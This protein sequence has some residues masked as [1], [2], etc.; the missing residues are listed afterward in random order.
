MHEY[1]GWRGPWIENE[2][3]SRYACRDYAIFYP[4][5]PIFVQATDACVLRQ[6]MPGVE[7]ALRDL[8]RSL[9]RDVI[10]VMV[11]QH[12]E[13][14]CFLPPEEDCEARNVILLSSG[15]WGNVALP[16]IKG[17]EAPSGAALP[18][19]GTAFGTASSYDVST[20]ISFA[21]KIETSVNGLRRQAVGALRDAGL[22]SE[23]AFKHFFGPQWRVVTRDSALPLSPRGYGR[24]SFRMSELVQMHLPQLYVYDDVPWLPYYD[25]AAPEGRP[26]RTDVW[27]E[28][29]VGFV[30]GPQ[31]LGNVTASLCA[32]MAADARFASCP[33]GLPPG[34]PYT[35]HAGSRVARMR[36][37]ASE[38]AASHF[39]L[40][41]VFD[42]I[43][44]FLQRPWD[45]D[46]VCV[47]KP[48]TRP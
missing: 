44:E 5:V 15:G 27:G 17:D 23:S 26:G 46:L 42:R 22:S 4:L 41:G 34:P 2:W 19:H 31:T 1:A 43:E 25:P 36:A 45:A 47:A 20:L 18:P 8:V 33:Q 29:G 16:L 14:L 48:A 39:T 10:Y 13:G 37:R 7:V 9:R 30:A 3:I 12:D 28:D 40:P 35:V 38:L 6:L 21:G 32:A 11:S 24:S